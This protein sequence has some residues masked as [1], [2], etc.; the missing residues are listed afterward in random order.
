MFES[1]ES[2]RLFSASLVDGLLTVEGTAGA[3]IVDIFGSTIT[4]NGTAQVFN[5][6]EITS[7]IVKLGE[8]DDTFTGGMD[9]P[10]TIFGGM[11]NDTLQ[12]GL[13]A[14]AIHA[15]KGNDILRGSFGNDT[16]FGG[17]G[18]DQMFGGR[19]NDLLNGGLGAD[20][21]SGGN[22]IDTADYSDR[23]VGLFPAP[24][25]LIITLDGIAN[26]GKPVLSCPEDM[27][28]VLWFFPPE[29]DNVLS[30]MEI[31]IGGAGN[32]SIT[33]DDGANTLI[34]GGGNDTLMG[35]GGG[36]EIRGGKG[37]D[38]LHGGMG[39]DTLTGGLGADRFFGGAGNDDLFADENSPFDTLDGGLDWDVAW[40]DAAMPGFPFDLLTNIEQGFSD[41]PV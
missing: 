24:D 23:V 26:D 41:D 21:F 40:H 39:N 11:G 6:E 25:D 3:D 18:D 12:G 1:L 35:G 20:L 5:M 9:R 10:I 2:R 22:G 14:E 32:D 17:E 28:C 37:D 4:I 33:G 29:M 34:G 19:G 30:N 38:N 13:G 31:I 27:V 16:L 36:D 7:V 15:G 8:G